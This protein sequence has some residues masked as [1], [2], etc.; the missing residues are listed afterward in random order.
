MEDFLI[1]KSLATI[2]FFM[3]TLPVRYMN[4]AQELQSTA[5]RQFVNFGAFE[6]NTE[7]ECADA[8]APSRPHESEC[9][10]ECRCRFWGRF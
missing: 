9:V 10:C 4:V 5:Q 1:C 3:Q 6:A 7:N 2:V 8:G